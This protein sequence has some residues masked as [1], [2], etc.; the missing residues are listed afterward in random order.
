[1]RRRY[2]TEIQLIIV[3]SVVILTILS[4]IIGIQVSF[5]FRDLKR[6]IDRMDKVLTNL[7]MLSS[8]IGQSAQSPPPKDTTAQ[9]ETSAAK[10]SR[11]AATSFGKRFFKRKEI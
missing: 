4:T 3:A 5:I 8:T 9:A 10:R 11:H 2:M 7:Q 6:V 1:M